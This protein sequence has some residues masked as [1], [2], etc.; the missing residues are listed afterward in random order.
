MTQTTPDRPRRLSMLQRIGIACAV[1]VALLVVAGAVLAASGSA[2]MAVVRTSLKAFGVAPAHDANGF[3]NVLLLGVG[4]ALHDGSDLTDTMILASIDPAT[5]SAVMLS[6]PRDLMVVTESGISRGRIN[7]LYAGEKYRLQHVHGL[8]ETEASQVALHDIGEEI[9]RQL[10]VEVHAVLKAD[11]TAF[12]STVDALGGVDVEV[13]KRIADYTYPVTERTTGLFE[14]DAGLQHLDGETALKYAR[15]RHSTSDFD[16]SAR[17]QQLIAAMGDKL[18][19]LGR[20]DQ[21]NFVRALLLDVSGHIE[22]TL[23]TPELL[24]LVQIG[25]E[26]SFDRILKYQLNFHI[27]GDTSQASAGGFVYPAPLEQFEGASVLVPFSLSGRMSDWGQIRTFAAL[28]MQHRDAYLSHPVIQIQ[29]ATQAQ[30]QAWRL[31][32]ELLRNGFDVEP[33]VQSG[34]ITDLPDPVLIRY[35]DDEQRPAATFLAT[36]LKGP[37]TQEQAGQWTGSGDILLLIDSSFRY[38][39]FQMSDAPGE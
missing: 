18:R 36:L 29:H 20:M 2:R 37:L 11:F 32:N 10:G 4:D 8:E 1:I 12:T 22:T 6:L 35:L 3:T 27:G 30:T 31:R 19:G 17:Q 21:V 24:G 13:P 5:R 14:L 25:S 9:G 33:L 34:A 39:R 26:L 15:S 23:S 16:R 28:T 7:A 38:T